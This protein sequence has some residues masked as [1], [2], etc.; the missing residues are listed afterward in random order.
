MSS[1]Y[2]V[3]RCSNLGC[4]KFSYCKSKQ[5]TKECPYCRKRINLEKVEKIPVKTN[6]QARRL[7]QEFNKKLGEL[8]EPKWYKDGKTNS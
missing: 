6:P 2:I 5:K 3:I 1:E 7:V 8:V 4:G